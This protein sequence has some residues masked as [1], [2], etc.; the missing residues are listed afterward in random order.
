VSPRVAGLEGLDPV[1][2]DAWST[3][4]GLLTDHG[5]VDVTIEE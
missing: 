1:Q 2:V 4:A 5:D 3:P